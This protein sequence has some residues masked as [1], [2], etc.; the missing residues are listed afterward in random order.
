MHCLNFLYNTTKIL[1]SLLL[2]FS[3]IVSA[4]SLNPL[5]PI[6]EYELKTWNKILETP[7]DRVFAINQDEEGYLWIGSDRGLLKFDGSQIKVIN[8][9]SDP[10]I[11]TE[12][13]IY[14]EFDKSGKLWFA[15]RRGVFYL[16]GNKAVQLYDKDNQKLSMIMNFFKDQNGVIWFVRYG[17]IYSIA[18]GIL[19][20]HNYPNPRLFRIFPANDGQ[21]YTLHTY[22][23]K[24]E[25]IFYK[26]DPKTNKTHKLFDEPV[27]M[28][29]FSIKDFGDDYVVGG[30]WGE[31]CLY[32]PGKG[33]VKQWVAKNNSKSPVRRILVQDDQTIW[34]GGVGFYRVH[35]DQVSSIF[36]EDGLTNNTIRSVFLD[37]DKNLWV[38]TMAGL[39]YFSNT[40]LH[41]MNK[42]EEAQN[43]A[44]QRPIDIDNQIIFGSRESGLFTFKNNQIEKLNVIGDI[45]NVIYET[46]ISINNHLLLSTNKGAF[47][48]QKI[49]GTYQVTKHFKKGE[50]YDFFQL[51]N[52]D[53][54][55]NDPTGFYIAKKDTLIKVRNSFPEIETLSRTLGKDWLSTNFGVYV[56][57][58][59]SLELSKLDFALEKYV[60]SLAQEEDST[61]WV[62]TYGSGIVHIQNDSTAVKYDTRNNLPANQAVMIAMSPSQGKWFYV[63]H[64]RQPYLQEII[65]VSDR[66]G[67]RINL[68]KKFRWVLLKGAFHEL[69]YTPQFINHQSELY[70]LTKHNLYLFRPR[71]VYYSPPTLSLQQLGINGE[72]LNTFPS[73]IEAD[74]EQLEFYLSKLDFSQGGTLDFEYKIEG[75]DKNWIKMGTRSVAYYNDIPAGKYT[76]NA[77]ILNS[78]NS[79]TYLSNPYNFVKKEF[80]FKTPLAKA[81][82]V[83]LFG[84]FIYLLFQWRLRVLKTQRRRLQTKVNERT[85]ELKYLN[86][87]LENIVKERTE[88]ITELNDNLYESEERLKYA[89]E[90]TKDGIWDYNVYYDTLK[91]SDASAEMLGYTLQ[92]CDPHTGILPFIHLDDRTLWLQT[93][94]EPR[95]QKLIDEIEDQEFRFY[96]KN[97]K[98]I[99]ILVKSKIVER[100]HKGDPLRIV[101]TYIDITEKKRKTQEILEAII[102]TED[103]ERSRISKDIH[104]GLQQTLTISSLNFQSVKKN[105]KGISP[106]L[107]EKFETGWNYLQKSITESRSV[108]HSLMPKAISDFGVISAFESLITEVDKSSEEI[109]FHFFHNFNGHQIKNRQVEVTL[110]RILQ[111]GINNIFKYSKATKVD[112]QLKN[113]DDIYMLTIEDNGI[114]FD[115]SKV[116]KDNSG[117]GFKGMKNRLDA[118]GGFLEIESREGRGT[119]LL[120]EINK[121]F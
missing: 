101:G 43:V 42:S 14:V 27:G 69:G 50:V 71:D 121:N 94:E 80:W 116:L 105:L 51:S 95:K 85:Q 92:D 4:Q 63:V 117:I 22:L 39:N 24:E 65:P 67:H 10:I 36:E 103:N 56:I 41:Q 34:A 17:K 106:T 3:G 8:L 57:E 59:D 46:A 120:I 28:M 9:K 18:D 30:L 110:Y 58:G 76:F 52:G 6:D 21:I 32:A 68:G 70:L 82:Y 99:W 114:G 78:D 118:I 102:R 16:E 112:I 19:K 11:E 15:T 54:I 23:K 2:G 53:Y 72:M 84:M 62:G 113:Y 75:Y 1:L 87:N 25:S 29:A 12:S 83:I 7:I 55:F 73:E 48:L 107:L 91:I 66:D 60:V 111:E 97:G 98:L 74:L 86:E 20:E 26:W 109:T 108:A 90:A 45:G 49:D 61:L 44:F 40:A 119:T 64:S 89:L 93:Y 47:E 79:Y 33:F 100:D 104:D 115:V 88:E 31:L 81:C 38:G 5:I 96:H 37:K 13:I 77:R 35:N